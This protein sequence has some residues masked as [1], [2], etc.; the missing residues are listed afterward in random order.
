MHPV[1]SG[2]L[3][4]WNP[5]GMKLPPSRESPCIPP[6]GALLQRSWRLASAPPDLPGPCSEQPPEKPSSRSTSH[7]TRMLWEASE[8]KVSNYCWHFW[9]V[10]LLA[11][12]VPWRASDV[13]CRP[14]CAE[15]QGWAGPM[16]LGKGE[17]AISS[18]SQPCLVSLLPFLGRIPL[19][20]LGFTPAKVQKLFQ[21]P[22]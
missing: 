12:A 15:F 4:K 19:S 10:L 20:W 21:G 13:I 3:Y 7:H 8:S 2:G 18:W 14:D 5:L 22:G 17:P 11:A 1:G 9:S 16:S 6:P